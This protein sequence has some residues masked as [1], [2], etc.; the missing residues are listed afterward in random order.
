M[1]EIQKLIAAANSHADG[2]AYK[3]TATAVVSIYREAY[4]AGKAAAAAGSYADGYAAGVAATV[5]VGMCLC[6]HVSV[7]HTADAPD[8]DGLRGFKMC[9]REDCDC[10]KY[11]PYLA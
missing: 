11:R 3:L 9:A 4:E 8:V 6:G 1:N 10:L 7:E 2:S 5:P